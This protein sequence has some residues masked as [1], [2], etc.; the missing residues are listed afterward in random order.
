MDTLEISML[1]EVRVFWNGK[2][3]TENLSSKA[4]AIVCLLSIDPKKS[5]SREKLINYF[6]DA[7]NDDAGKYNLRY[8]LWSI[9]KILKIDENNESIISTVKD[10]CKINP[11]V[12]VITD[13]CEL[14]EILTLLEEENKD[15]YIEKLE[16]A[17]AY[18]SG[19][20]LEGVYLKKCLEFNDWVFYMREKY[21]R[22]YLDML[23]SLSRAYVLGKNY[24]KAIEVLEVMI[25]LNPLQEELYVEIIQIYLKMGNR[26]KALYQY[27]K[28][29]D[30]LR[31]ELNVSPMKSTKEIYQKIIELEKTSYYIK[32]PERKIDKS[33]HVRI[34]YTEKE[35]F[36]TLSK[37]IF[38]ADDCFSMHTR[39]YPIKGIDYYWM[40]ELIECILE[41]K[42][43]FDLNDFSVCNWMDLAMIQSNILNFIDENNNYLKYSKEGART[44]IFSAMNNLLNHLKKDGKIIIFIEKF[45]WIDAVSFE[46]LKYFCLKSVNF[47]GTLVISG[48]HKDNKFKELG[49]FI[50]IEE[51]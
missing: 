20:F 48:D 19:E 14:D 22:M 4:I 5:Y 6:W 16:S 3:I 18:F 34:I 31:D 45:Q 24:L 25:R 44:R 50:H 37:N 30:M 38:Y 32:E 2:N 46:F 9:R 21:Q 10:K 49:Q 51:M 27:Q 17:R 29:C 13:I 42:G 43:M 35:N 23:H 39:C 12:E 40:S 26:K 11:K 15:D 41:R 28:C 36:I 7:S 47:N 33:E 1:G 8:S